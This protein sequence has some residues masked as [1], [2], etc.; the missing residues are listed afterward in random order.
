MVDF[1]VNLCVCISVDLVDIWQGLGVFI[2]QLCEVCMEVVRLL[3]MKNNIM[4]LG[5][6]VG[7]MVQVMCQL[8]VQFIDIFISL[9]G[10]MF[11]FIVL[12]QQGGQIKDSFG[13]VELVLKGVLLVLLGM[14]NLYIVVVVVV[15]LVVY[16]WYDVEQQV[17]VYMKVFVLLC[18]EVVV[19]ILMFVIMVQKI[20]D[21]LQ[22]VVGVGVEVVQVVGLNGKIVVQNFQDVVNVVVVMKEI[23]GQV[24]DEIIVMYVKL[25]EDLVKGMQKF[26]EQVNFMILVFYEQ[27]KVLQEQGWNQ[28]VVIVI[29][30]VVVDEIVM[31]FV[32]VCVSQN[33]VI[34]GFKDLWVEV[35]KVW[36]VMQVS[37]GFGLVVV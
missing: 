24:F 32:W 4:E 20:S 33:L 16:V 8:L 13:G 11:F 30:C 12:V 23:S 15:G 19:M 37:V 26:N 36:L 3:L 10:G 9:Q 18:N 2:C 14:V 34:W 25:V 5:V 21:V 31:V 27:V 28:D 7:Q 6:F 35:M 29:I 17:Q 1:L 22:V